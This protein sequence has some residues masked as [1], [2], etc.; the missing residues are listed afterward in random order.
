MKRKIVLLVLHI[1]ELFLICLFYLT[2]AA[3]YVVPPKLLIWFYKIFGYSL[4]YF[5]PGVK[6]NL[7]WTLGEALPEKSDEERGKIAKRVCAESV[8][9]MCDMVLFKRY[10]EKFARHMEWIGLDLY[11]EAEALNK[12]I[13]G[14]SCH[15]GMYTLDAAIPNLIGVG[16]TLLIYNPGDTMLPRWVKMLFD[17]LHGIGCDPDVP[18]IYA[19]QEAKK[20][21]TEHIKSGKF[22]GI[23]MD[24]GGAGITEVFGKPAA[25]AKGVP[26]FAIDTGAPILSCNIYRTDI[27]YKV[28]VVIRPKLEYELTG[29]R[30]TDQDIIMKEIGKALEEQVLYAPDQWTNWF[31]LRMWWRK[32][33]KF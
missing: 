29:D 15:T 10:E 12:G 4:Y 31:G 5:M 7:L 17:F 9:P 13:I 20:T 23:A 18:F 33:E 14:I 24:V 16:G 27:W 6:K 19:T 8:L 3:V 2:R 28:K 30:K 22:L 21:A 26:N 11:R 32:A 25:I 1:A